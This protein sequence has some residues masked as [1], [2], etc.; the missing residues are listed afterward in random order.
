MTVI[1]EATATQIGELVAEFAEQ[2]LL[3]L[4]DESA[5]AELHDITVLHK[6]QKAT[7][8]IT[9]NDVLLIDGQSFPIT[10]VGETANKTLQELGHVTIKFD[11][12][13]ADLP[14][15]ICVEEK[16]V[17]SVQAGTKIQFIRTTKN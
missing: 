5:P 4:F 1:F 13:K 16:P 12:A 6:D 11:G 10:F 17:P 8:D 3:I 15:S 7:G 14:G 2:K 9:T